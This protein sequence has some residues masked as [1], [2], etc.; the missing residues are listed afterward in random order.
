MKQAEEDFGETPRRGASF[1]LEVAFSTE[2]GKNRKL[3]LRV[4]HP[5]GYLRYFRR[6][7]LCM[8]LILLASPEGLNP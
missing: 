5:F 1:W 3:N 6:P 2:F 8:L 4:R 7:I